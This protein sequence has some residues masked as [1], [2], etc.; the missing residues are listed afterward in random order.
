MGQEYNPAVPPKF[1]GQ[2]DAP[3]SHIIMRCRYNGRLPSLILS[4]KWPICDCPL[5]SIHLHCNC[6]VFT[7]NN[8]LQVSDANYY[9]QSSVFIYIYTITLQRGLSS[10][11]ALFQ[12]ILANDSRL[13]LTICRIF[14]KND[15]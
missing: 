7:L 15:E 13:S 3:Y 9:S 14:N 5:E 10:F 8:S 6:C 11:F 12:K 4:A 2:P 1:I